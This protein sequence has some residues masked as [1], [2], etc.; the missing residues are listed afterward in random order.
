MYKII[1]AFA[2]SSLF[3][4]LTSAQESTNKTIQYT[5]T[6]A[7]Q[8]IT[9]TGEDSLNSFGINHART[10]ISGYGELQYHRDNNARVA[11][12]DLKRAVLFVGHQF[13]GKIAF[14][15]ELEVEDAKIAAGG[16]AGEVGMEQAYLKFSLNPRQYIVAGLFLPRIGIINEN[17][18]PINFNGVERPQVEQLIIPSTWREIGVGFYGQT[19]TLPFT[20][21]VA[22]VNGLNNATFEHGTG[23]E[24]GRAE[25]QLAGANNLAITAAVQYFAGNWKFQVSGYAGGTTTLSPAKADSMKL[26]SGFLGAP[27]YLG[28]ADIQYS[29]KGLSIKALGCVVSIPEAASINRAYTNNTPE[30]MYGAYMELG[31]NLLQNAPRAKAANKQL[32]IFARYEVLDLNTKIPGNGIYDGTEQQ[33][34]LVAGIGYFPIPNVVIKADVRLLHTG[35]PDAVLSYKQ[36]NSFINIGIGYSF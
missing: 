30:Q 13:T 6:P 9:T 2:C 5:Q 18:L 22:L 29:N 27:L 24:S 8:L 32:N 14:F 20:Y 17:H 34:H 21:S 4:N 1:F 33:T 35:T 7:Q 25:G 10:V 28:E 31:Y 26:S 23:F 3:I 12:A 16:F 36:N 15:S 19:T 11:T